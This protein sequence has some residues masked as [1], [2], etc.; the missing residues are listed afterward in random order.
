MSDVQIIVTASGIPICPVAVR[1]LNIAIKAANN[2]YG[3]ATGKIMTEDVLRQHLSAALQREVD[4]DNERD[5]NE[6]IPLSKV[7]VEGIGY[8]N[9]RAN[10]RGEACSCT[11]D[12]SYNG[13]EF[14]YGKSEEVEVID[15]EPLSTEESDDE[16]GEG[17]NEE[18]ETTDAMGNSTEEPYGRDDYVAMS[19]PH[20]KQIAKDRELAGFNGMNKSDLIEFLVEND[21][22]DEEG[23]DD[24][25]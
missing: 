1:T 2:Q 22:A 12:T 24:E 19:V 5:G 17:A 18:Q 16:S 20:L 10:E 15:A 3:A 6:S 21:E 4:V 11:L 9:W 14:T 25:D 8:D 23:Y 13:K 7:L